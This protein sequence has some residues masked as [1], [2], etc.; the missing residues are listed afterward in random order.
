MDATVKSESL[1]T[2][3]VRGFHFALKETIVFRAG[4]NMTGKKGAPQVKVGN[5]VEQNVPVNAALY[6]GQIHKAVLA[7]TLPSSHTSTTLNSARHIDITYVLVVKAL[8]GAG[9]PLSMDLPVIVSNWPRY[10]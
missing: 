6:G 10:V 3:V 9:K 8:M 4:P 7:V 1:N 2:V 5:I